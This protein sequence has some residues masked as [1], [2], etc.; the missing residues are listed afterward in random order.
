VFLFQQIGKEMA[1]K[2]EVKMVDVT[3]SIPEKIGPIHWVMG[4]N[5]MFSTD[6][7]NDLDTQLKVEAVNKLADTFSNIR[8]QLICAMVMVAVE[9]LHETMESLF[10]DDDFEEEALH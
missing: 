4:E 8:V 9:A 2:D 6:T 10:D 3:I 5:G 7:F 1:K